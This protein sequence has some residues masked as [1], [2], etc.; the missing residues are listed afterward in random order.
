[1]S[2][3]GHSTI[4]AAEDAA[5]ADEEVKSD[6][7]VIERPVQTA[8]PV[9]AAVEEDAEDDEYDLYRSSPA[10]SS[11]P[12]APVELAMTNPEKASRFTLVVA[13]EATEAV[14]SERL[15]RRMAAMEPAFLR[16]AAI[17]AMLDN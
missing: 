12:A 3:K 9:M 7:P 8:Q 6:Y 4:F 16:I 2:G 15:E 13:D 11:A 10:P 1:M 14:L 17:T 5:S